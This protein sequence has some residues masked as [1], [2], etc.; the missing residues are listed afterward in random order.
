[1]LRLL[2]PPDIS[3]KVQRSRKIYLECNLFFRAKTVKVYRFRS[4]NTIFPKQPF[5]LN[6][7]SILVEYRQIHTNGLTNR[8]KFLSFAFHGRRWKFRIQGRYVFGGSKAM[9]K[10]TEVTAR[11]MSSCFVYLST[12]SSYT[13]NGYV[14]TS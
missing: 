6:F 5:Y 1:M 2:F 10:E 3:G 13:T 8:P 14:H 11:R 7:S 9:A 4:T 12:G